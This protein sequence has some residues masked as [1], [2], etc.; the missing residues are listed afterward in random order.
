MRKVEPQTI[1]R[2]ERACLPDVRAKD[3]AQ[4][5]MQQVCRGMVACDIEPALRLHRGVYRIANRNLAARNVRSMCDE[6]ADR[7]LRIADTSSPALSADNARIS[8]LP[9]ALR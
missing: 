6:V 3:I 5:R 9:T 2:D 4:H 7:P 8:D 1:R